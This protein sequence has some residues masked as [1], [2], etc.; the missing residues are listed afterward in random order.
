MR[1]IVFFNAMF[2]GI[3]SGE[4]EIKTI[5]RFAAVQILQ[6]QPTSAAMMIKM[7]DFGSQRTTDDYFSG[8]G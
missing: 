7:A 6:A 8:M 4:A 1:L 3:V 5:H 2:P